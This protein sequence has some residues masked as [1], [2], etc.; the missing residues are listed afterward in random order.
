MCV[1]MCVLH[2]V[3]FC[4]V[5]KETYLYAKRDLFVCQ[6]RPTLC[7]VA[8]ARDLYFSLYFSL[9]IYFFLSLLPVITLCPLVCDLVFV[10]QGGEELFAPD[11]AKLA[12]FDL[13][14][15]KL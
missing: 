12:M 10:L 9:L 3:S 13:K 4:S 15:G 6:N 7:S 8:R 5:R 1:C 11:L 14:A 2:R